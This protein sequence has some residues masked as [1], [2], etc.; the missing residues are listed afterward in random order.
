MKILICLLLSSIF[1]AA[2]SLPYEHNYKNERGWP[3]RMV[4]FQSPNDPSV[5]I[6]SLYTYMDA[7]TPYYK[8]KDQKIANTELALNFIAR[9]Q[10]VDAAI[11]RGHAASDAAVARVVADAREHAKAAPEAEEIDDRGSQEAAMRSFEET[12][13]R[14]AIEANERRIE[15]L[16]RKIKK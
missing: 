4:F 15:E 12:K 5:I 14:H 1:S 9:Q 11:A 7:Q 3:E 10:S 16:E 8:L 6:I 13:R 2:Q